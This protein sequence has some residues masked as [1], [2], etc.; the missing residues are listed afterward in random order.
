MAMQLQLKFCFTGKLLK[1]ESSQYCHIVIFAI[2]TD[3]IK[4]EKETK[5]RN[6]I[7]SSEQTKK[8]VNIKIYEIFDYH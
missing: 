2:L 4:A 7:Q 3:S 8:T 1:R 5:Q 6:P